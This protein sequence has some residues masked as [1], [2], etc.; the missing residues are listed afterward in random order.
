[1]TH[2]ACA[3]FSF[4]PN[5][6]LNWTRR[7]IDGGS[8]N[9][10]RR[11]HFLFS[12][13]RRLHSVGSIA[14]TAIGSL[15]GGCGPTGHLDHSQVANWEKVTDQARLADIAI[16]AG[17]T[18]AVV[19]H[20]QTRAKYWKAW[21]DRSARLAAVEGVTDE[22][23]LERIVKKCDNRDFAAIGLDG[24]REDVDRQQASFVDADVCKYAVR[25]MRDQ[26][27]LM[28]IAMHCQ[29]HS[30]ALVAAETLSDQK[31]LARVALEGNDSI[32][33]KISA[34]RLED[35]AL[36]SEVAGGSGASRA[37]A[38]LEA[39]R[40]IAV[41]KAADQ[42]LLKKLASAD[43]DA[44]VRLAAVEDLDDEPTL[45]HVATTDP[46]PSVRLTAIGQ[47]RSPSS[48]RSFLGDKRNHA[49][50][51]AR[52][53]LI[54]IDPTVQSVVGETKIEA[55][56]QSLTES[57]YESNGHM[58]RPGFNTPPH[59]AGT[60]SGEWINIAICD[61]Q[62][63]WPY[64][65]MQGLRVETGFHFPQVL[66]P[67]PVIGDWRTEFPGTTYGLAF[68]P[69]QVDIGTLLLSLL[70]AKVRS[71]SQLVSLT[72]GSSDPL[73][74]EAVKKRLAEIQDRATSRTSSR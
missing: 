29:F 74:L 18:G 36:I 39:V 61:R 8:N 13:K 59:Y 4:P 58:V 52:L 11:W 48:I 50:D 71:P 7:A 45:I 35:P 60:M 40:V 16:A 30:V 62:L 33:R 72:A 1:M 10:T 54:L 56:W 28:G 3:F 55:H 44:G 51:V 26:R 32:A 20:D 17:D 31:L 73:L 65:V 43:D 67:W 41:G 24:S 66:P 12:R 47:L 70:A 19:D 23:L 63:R 38:G 69:A 27:Y 21:N 25:K 64:G 14:I 34:A 5:R 9:K 15:C 68:R 6:R 2:F 53:R 22:A 57:Y 46:E 49:G 37:G 42:S